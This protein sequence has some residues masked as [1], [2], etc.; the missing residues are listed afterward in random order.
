MVVVVFFLNNK[1]FKYFFHQFPVQSEIIVLPNN[2]L[3][4]TEIYINGIALRHIRQKI[5]VFRLSRVESKADRCK[6]RK[7]LFAG[8]K[9]G[10]VTS[11]LHTTHCRSDAG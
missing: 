9:E 3:S 4:F 11:L 8:I 1:V 10:N 6:R 2:Y 7:V 5:A